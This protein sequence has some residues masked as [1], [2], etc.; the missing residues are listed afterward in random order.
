MV[1]LMQ[2]PPEPDEGEIQIKE[3]PIVALVKGAIIYN[4][5]PLIKIRPD[6]NRRRE[7]LLLAD[8]YLK[9][10]EGEV[11]QS[12]IL[13]TYS[14]ANVY[15]VDGMK[16]PNQFSMSFWGQREKKTK[17][18]LPEPELR[19]RIYRADNSTTRDTWLVW[20]RM[21]MRQYWQSEL[22][23]TVI[24]K[25]AFYQYHQFVWQV[26]SRGGEENIRLLVLDTE[27][28]HL[29]KSLPEEKIAKPQWTLSYAAIKRFVRFKGSPEFWE[30]HLDP[31]AITSFPDCR[32]VYLFR[33]KG[34]L[35]VT[36]MG[37]E[38]A[39]VMQN[40]EKKCLETEEK[41]G[42]APGK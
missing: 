29:V 6:G 28:F 7:L 36:T 22:E 39:R 31:S 24:A 12:G 33:A 3:P 11:Q 32:E 4:W 14:M 9:C 41:D 13:A 40:A 34:P 42:P 2:A 5:G 1:S 18:K 38:L 17:A 23:K 37:Q 8:R 15:S 19:E 26:R 30:L 10:K 16:Q 21:I 25:P 27:K 35:Q 20:W